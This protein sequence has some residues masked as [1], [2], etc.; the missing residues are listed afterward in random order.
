MGKVAGRASHSIRSGFFHRL[1]P[2][3]PTNY[4]CIS[5]R[6]GLWKIVLNKGFAAK[7]EGL[8]LLFSSNALISWTKEQVERKRF[9]PKAT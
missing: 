9:W 2:P 8:K 3:V 7:E 6:A 5:K 4:S 1:N